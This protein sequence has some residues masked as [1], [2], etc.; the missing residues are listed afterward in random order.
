M[1]RQKMLFDFASAKYVGVICA[2]SDESSIKI[3][4]DFLQFL[5]Q[6]QIKYL[7][8]GYFD[9]KKIPENFLFQKETDFITRSDLNLFFIP[10]GAVVTRFVAEPFDILINCSMNRYFPAEYITQISVAKCKVGASTGDIPDYDLLI[11]ISKKRDLGYFLDN[12]RLYLSNLR[13]PNYT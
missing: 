1:K 5:R 3:L 2:S 10:K 13:N 11:D 8:L 4:K 12:V 6:H 7:V 9:G